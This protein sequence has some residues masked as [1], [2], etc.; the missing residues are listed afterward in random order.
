MTYSK[1][2]SPNQESV[3]KTKERGS[4]RG[5][6]IEGTRLQERGESAEGTEGEAYLTKS[7]RSLLSIPYY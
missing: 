2:D 5:I 1:P 6:P 3:Q 7:H 4:G